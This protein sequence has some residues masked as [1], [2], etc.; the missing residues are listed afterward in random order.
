MVYTLS[1]MTDLRSRW[2]RATIIE[3]IEDGG[4]LD[5]DAVIMVL[6][7]AP[8]PDPPRAQPQE[9]GADQLPEAGGVHWV[10]LALAAV[11][12]IVVVQG[13]PGQ[14]HALMNNDSTSFVTTAS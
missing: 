11:L 1:E 6:G 5:S 7:V 4:W 8:G 10:L 12:Q 9:H 3:P 13:G 2:R 14:G